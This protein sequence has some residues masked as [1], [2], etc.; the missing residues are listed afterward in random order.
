MVSPVVASGFTVHHLGETD[1]TNDWLLAA[2]RDGAPNRTVAVADFQ[3]AGRGRLD[4]R[5]EAPAGSSLLC[6]LLL[7]VRLAPQDRHRCTVAVALAAAEACE[8]VAGTPVSLKW[9]N[10]LV[11]ADRKLA[12]VLAETDGVTDDDG[13]T[14][15]VVGLGC[16]L[17]WPGPPEAGGTSLLEASGR[18]VERDALLDATLGALEPLLAEVRADG[19]ALAARYRSRLVTL[20]RAVRVELAGA[21]FEGVARDV[22][23]AGALVVDT[24]DG[25]RT[26]TAGDVVHVR[27][28]TGRAEGRE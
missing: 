22:T 28:G 6:S 26:V 10:D 12:G 13:T 23:D 11:I 16:N 5:W 20:G 9:P 4:R 24:P 14:A 17:T 8:A 27:A 1:S 21:A 7:R 3:R 15:V 2:A 19:P 18:H 25:T